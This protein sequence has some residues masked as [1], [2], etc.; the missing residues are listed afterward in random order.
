MLEF[1]QF[2]ENHLG[3]VIDKFLR[4]EIKP[5]PQNNA[6]ATWVC[7]RNHDDCKITFAGNCDLIE[8]MFAALVPPYPEPILIVNSKKYMTTSARLKRVEY[9]SIVGAVV[10]FDCGSAIIKLVDGLLYVNGFREF[11]SEMELLPAA[12]LR[13]G[14][15]LI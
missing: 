2:V 8:A 11:D 14:Q 10:G 1:D 12:V 7:R 13:V 5:F 15:R 6:L 3:E 4:G 9:L